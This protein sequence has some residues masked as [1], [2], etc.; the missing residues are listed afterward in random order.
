MPLAPSCD[1]DAQQLK[2][3]RHLAQT[4]RETLDPVGAKHYPAVLLL[5][6]FSEAMK[7]AYTADQ[8]PAWTCRSILQITR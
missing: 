5:A 3:R 8:P 7:P 2:G 4:Q 6:P 1:Q